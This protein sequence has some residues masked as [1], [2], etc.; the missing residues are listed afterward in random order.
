MVNE[1]AFLLEPDLNFEP[2]AGVSGLSEDILQR[3][4]PLLGSSTTTPG[5]WEH[6]VITRSG[7]DAITISQ[8]GVVDWCISASGN[9][10]M[11]I[12][13]DVSFSATG[14]KPQLIA[15]GNG[16]TTQT[17]TATGT[18]D[19]EQLSVVVDIPFDTKVVVRAF[20]RDNS[21]GSWAEFSNWFVGV[22]D[23]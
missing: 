22:E 4:R 18:G 12:S 19:K 11:T 9:T 16:I 3:P 1:L 5:P 23:A 2:E 21:S 17:A 7:L 14:D 15:F 13:C 8:R 6:S 20:A 10:T